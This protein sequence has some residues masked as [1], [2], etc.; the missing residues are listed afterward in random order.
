M[1]KNIANILTYYLEEM[2]K[3]AC[4]PQYQYDENGEIETDA[5]GKP[6]QAPKTTWGYDNWEVEFMQ[7][8]KKK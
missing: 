1:I 2:F 6:V 5:E 4:E 3:E 7:L 8:G